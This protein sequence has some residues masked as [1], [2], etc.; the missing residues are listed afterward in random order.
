MYEC[1][2]SVEHHQSRLRPTL[3]P[4][5]RLSPPSLPGLPA[6]LARSRLLLP[7][8][9]LLPLLVLL[10]ALNHQSH[11]HRAHA[12]DG[13]MGGMSMSMTFIG[14]TR[15]TLWVDA[16]TTTSATGYLATLAFLL[17]LS[18]AQEGLH[19]VRSS[20][21]L[22]CVV[23]PR[24]LVSLRAAH[25]CAL[26]GC[27]N[28]SLFAPLALITSLSQLRSRHAAVRA[29]P[30]AVLPAHAGG[31]DLQRGRVPGRRGRPRS[32]EAP[33]GATRA[34]RNGCSPPRGAAKRTQCAAE[35]RNVNLR[36]L[37]RANGAVSEVYRPTS[38]KACS[39]Q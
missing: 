10:N 33:H 27:A 8:L 32:R 30:G 11:V 1:P 19:A 14:S 16:W 4:A 36:R 39:F 23:T 20:S 26:P 25:C 18:V 17:L 6:T 5:R 34:A 28:R 22:G 7:A 9:L 38:V 31:D 21:P 3:I 2:W 35:Q 13:G 12:M 24:S 29:E 15:L 37:L